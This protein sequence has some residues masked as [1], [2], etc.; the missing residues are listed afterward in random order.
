[1]PNRLAQSASPYLKQ[2]AENPVDWYEWGPEP[3]D[4]A[5]SEDKP[6]LLSVGYS[7]CHW[8]HVMAHESFEDPDT[9]RLM[10]ELFVNIKVDR[11]ERP[12]IDSVYM[13][14]TQAMTGQGGWPMTV[15]LTPGGEPFYAGT[16]FPDTD[17]GGMPSFR[18]VMLAVSDAWTNR[19]EEVRTHGGR[20]V[21]AIGRK[22]PMAE[23]LGDRKTLER[24]YSQLEAAYDPVSGGF[25]GAPKFPQQP[26]LDFLLR[27]HREEWA[28]RASSMLRQTLRRMA[29]G[30]IHD[31][32]GG[33]FARY[34]V[35]DRWLVPHFEKMLYDN[36]QLARIYGWAAVELDE[37][38]FTEIA[39]S[40]LAYMIRDLR[41]SHGGFFSAE[42]ADSEG[43]EGKFYVWSADEIR[44]AA[45][46]EAPLVLDLWG[47]RPEGNFEGANILH[48]ALTPAEVA[49]RHGVSIEHVADVAE[50]TRANLFEL[51]STRARPGLDDKVVASWNGMAM[52]ALSEVGAVTGSEDL[53]DAADTCARFVRDNMYLD[54][55]LHRTW[56]AG[57]LG[58]P[59]FLEDYASVAVGLLSV[60]AATGDA[61]HYELAIEI[62][63]RIP[64]LFSDPEGGFFATA[65]DA[66]KLIRRP[67]D[68]MDNPLPSGSSLAAELFGML[69]GYTGEHEYGELHTETIKSAGVL[70]ER[71]PSAVGHLLGVLAGAVSDPREVA[72]VGESA[73]ELASVYW[74]R[75]RPGT[76]LAVSAGPEERIPLLRGRSVEGRTLAYVCRNFTCESPVSTAA[77]L[78]ALL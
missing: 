45:G 7:A 5:R 16:Y 51:R 40:T 76:V 67:K 6:V 77:E 54:G 69:A 71:Y 8:C 19:R 56:T 74:E 4:R 70:P 75:M 22:I 52:R 20:L 65:D 30:G 43:E 53:L 1:V 23:R 27:I 14:A 21:E 63:G 61:D 11:E 47:V 78:R 35:D 13:E 55:R 26:V 49:E 72:I 46:V 17:R 41:G 33:G 9:A 50:T 39:L 18:R 73:G 48:E 68:Q 66:E 10:N 31:V 57:A 60:F 15:W 38:R 62:A 25:G 44:H 3:F 12:D 37:P 42:D 29:A 24:A 32:V 64:E 36:A 58:P 34:S 2:H 28:P 59:G